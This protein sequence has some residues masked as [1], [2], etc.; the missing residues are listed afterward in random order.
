MQ[1][2]I[3]FDFEHFEPAMEEAGK[4]EVAENAEK[5]EWTRAKLSWIGGIV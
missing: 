3:L 1:T 2:S 4:A 5:A